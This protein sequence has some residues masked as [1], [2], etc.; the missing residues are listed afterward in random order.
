MAAE[1]SQDRSVHRQSS[2]ERQPAAE[3]YHGRLSASQQK[4]QGQDRGTATLEMLRASWPAGISS[5]VSPLRYDL[6]DTSTPRDVIAAELDKIMGYDRTVISNPV[7]ECSREVE[8][9]CNR[10][11]GGLCANLAADLPPKV[12][13]AKMYCK[14]LQLQRTAL[15]ANSNTKNDDQHLFDSLGPWGLVALS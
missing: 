8:R 13:L 15:N 3:A 2:F 7:K 10:R 11:F 5:Y 12:L 6:V 1:I 4:R 14:S 9:M